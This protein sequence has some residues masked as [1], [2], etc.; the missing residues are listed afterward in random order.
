MK[1]NSTAAAAYLAFCLLLLLSRGNADANGNLLCGRLFRVC[2]KLFADC[3]AHSALLL[4]WNLCVTL[5]HLAPITIGELCV[6][7]SLTYFYYSRTRQRM[8]ESE[9]LRKA[10][11]N[12][13]T[14]LALHNLMNVIV[15][16]RKFEEETV[17]LR[18]PLR[19]RSSMPRVSVPLSSTSPEPPPRALTPTFHSPRMSSSPPMSLERSSLAHS[20]HVSSKLSVVSLN[21]PRKPEDGALERA[22]SERTLAGNSPRASPRLTPE[23]PRRR[24]SIGG[25][26]LNKKPIVVRFIVDPLAISP[27]CD[28]Y[29]IPAGRMSMEHRQILSLAQPAAEKWSQEE[30]AP[31]MD[32][33]SLVREIQILRRRASLL[34]LKRSSRHVMPPDADVSHDEGKYAEFKQAPSWRPPSDESKFEVLNVVAPSGF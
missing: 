34:L 33:Y 21:E 15:N 8:S 5:A 30:S 18:S 22:K 23:T 14:P 9:I 10:K 3:A 1:R 7:N 12:V 16:E 2:V 11:A 28:L 17:S 4:L 26:V 29:F 6:N 27:E 32:E 31:K 19:R 20:A 13:I 25:S 24:N